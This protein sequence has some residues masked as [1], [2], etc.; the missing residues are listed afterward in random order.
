MSIK[1]G[2]AP[3]SWGIWFDRDPLQM[4]WQRVLDEMVLAGYEWVE[5]GPFG[6]LPTEH[7]VLAHEL[8]ERGLK[9]SAGFVKGHLEDLGGRAELLKQAR[10]VGALLRDVGAHYLVLLDEPYQDLRT[11]EQT[12]PARLSPDEWRNLVET[13]HQ[14]ADVARQEFNLGLLFEAHTACHVEYQDQIETLLADTDPT[15][16]SL[17]LDVGHFGFRSSDPVPFFQKHHARIP[18]VHLKSIDANVRRQVEAA[19]LSFPEAV[20]KG[21][22]CEPAL[23]ELDFDKLLAVLR[24]A[25]F[26]GWAIVE[27]GMYPAPF[28][29]PLPIAARTRNYLREK[30]WG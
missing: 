13:I 28:D 2:T 19:N 23:G 17:L 26:D 6:F 10:T 11:G 20:R 15:R 16:V 8:Q 9:L 30:G 27:Q 21:I 29:K 3:S 7:A 5:L 12:R 1:I 14:V 24:D 25:E 18:Y 4:P 22:F